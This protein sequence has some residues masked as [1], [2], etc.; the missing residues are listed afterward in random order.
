MTVQTLR[1]DKDR[2]ATAIYM[3]VRMHS[4]SRGEMELAG[5]VNARWEEMMSAL[6]SK[7]Y[8]GHC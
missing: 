8:D 6:P 5:T 3:Y 4:K 1:A 7:N 2:Y